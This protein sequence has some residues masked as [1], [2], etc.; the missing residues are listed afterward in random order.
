MTNYQAG[1]AEYL[2]PGTGDEMPRR[3]AKV[4]LL[5]LG[6][7]HTN[8]PWIDDGS[9]LGWLPLPKRNQEKEDLI[10]AKT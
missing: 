1:G 4:Q 10:R 5:T 6:G 7:I 8:G 9:Y 2:Y 3:G